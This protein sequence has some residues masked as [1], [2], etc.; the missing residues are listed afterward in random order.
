MN[1]TVIRVLALPACIVFLSLL[2]SSHGAS[3]HDAVPLKT[4]RREARITLDDFLL[5]DQGARPFHFKDLTG[6]VVL[7][8]FV[9]TSCT[10]VCPLITSAVGQVQS[11][12]SATER[13][14]V[15]LLSITTDPEIDSPGVL[16]AYAKRYKADF[17]NWSF[18]T[19]SMVELE[20][21]WKSFGVGV[22]RKGRGIVEHTPLTVLV[23]RHRR[24]RYAY[25]GPTPQSKLVLADLRALLAE[26][27]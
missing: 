13:A 1:F 19:G 25:I 8:S 24:L 11:Q 22:K 17:R 12:L 16:M 2:S 26:R 15:H 5:I 27:E 18:L 20:S 6:K 21:V 7:V 4:E 10:D 9:Y 23:D 14:A 3:H